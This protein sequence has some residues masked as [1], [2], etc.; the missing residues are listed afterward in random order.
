MTPQQ[1]TSLRWTRPLKVVSGTSTAVLPAVCSACAAL[2][3]ARV[4]V[5]HVV[6]A[7]T[8]SYSFVK[9]VGSICGSA[10]CRAAAAHFECRE[11][12]RQERG[13]RHEVTVQRCEGQPTANH[14]P[15]FVL[16]F[17]CSLTLSGQA[18]MQKLQ[19][20]MGPTSLQSCARTMSER[21]LLCCILPRRLL[22]LHCS[23]SAPSGCQSLSATPM[24]RDAQSKQQQTSH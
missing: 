24:R 14:S 13:T 10:F 15:K 9:R 16:F 1:N 11:C 2:E 18:K 7:Q 3:C 21:S 5:S 22:A 12:I 19:W 6:A 17:G 20:D 4:R 8:S 23:P